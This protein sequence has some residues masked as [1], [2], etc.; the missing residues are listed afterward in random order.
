MGRR[1]GVARSWH[2]EGLFAPAGR[3]GGAG[4]WHC[5]GRHRPERGAGPWHVLRRTLSP[6]RAGTEGLDPGTAKAF[7]PL[8]AGRD[9]FRSSNIL[10]DIW[11]CPP[12]AGVKRLDTPGGSQNGA[13]DPFKIHENG[14]RERSENTFWNKWVPK[15]LV[16]ILFVQFL[17]PLGRYCV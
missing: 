16:V 14:A 4:P 13:K 10:I 12:K 2:C 9:P 8:R 1:N 15:C 7:S 17:M 5:E 3:N 6:V 11:I